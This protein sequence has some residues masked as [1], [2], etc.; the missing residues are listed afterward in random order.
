MAAA[1]ELLKTDCIFCWNDWAKTE[2]ED[3]VVTGA[4]GCF[5]ATVHKSC[6][7]E[8][9]RHR[10]EQ[11]C[12][13]CPHCRMENAFPVLRDLQP[14]EVFPYC[15]RMQTAPATVPAGHIRIPFGLYQEYALQFL[16]ASP[17][18][19][20]NGPNLVSE[21]REISIRRTSEDVS[22]YYFAYLVMN[23]I[24]FKRVWAWGD[25]EPTPD[26]SRIF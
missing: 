1:T 2:T 11:Q 26:F 5:Y 21:T 4:C 24:T 19:T 12:R 16:E 14:G 22:N 6:A 8:S 7:K 20:I 23:E 10:S 9:Q 18:E 25:D 13:R 17:P 3:P 15:I